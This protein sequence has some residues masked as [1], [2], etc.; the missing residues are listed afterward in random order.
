MGVLPLQYAT[1]ETADSLGLTGEEEFSIIGV[2]AIND[3]TTPREVT[4]RAGQ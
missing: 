4:V 3:G 2:E 1:G